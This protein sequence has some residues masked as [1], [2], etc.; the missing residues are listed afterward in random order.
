V[1]INIPA[2]CCHIH[3]C[4]MMHSCVA[5]LI[6]ICEIAHSYTTCLVFVC[7]FTCMAWLFFVWHCPLICDMTHFYV[8]WPICVWHGSF[9]C[10]VTHPYVTWL[11]LVWHDS[12]QACMNIHSRGCLMNM[13][14]FKCVTYLILYVTRLIVG[15]HKH[16]FS[17]LPHICVTWMVPLWYDACSFVTC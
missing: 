10:D 17:W 6:D 11:I 13:C 12:L 15:A 8:T 14:D 9:L 16:P 3:T 2:R 1:R 4:D 7:N 5:R